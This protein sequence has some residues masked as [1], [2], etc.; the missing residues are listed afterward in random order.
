[1]IFEKMLEKS[2]YHEFFVKI[3]RFFRYPFWITMDNE[4]TQKNKD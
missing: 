1:L 3:M 4:K 2:A